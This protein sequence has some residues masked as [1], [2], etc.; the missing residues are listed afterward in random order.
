MKLSEKR[1]DVWVWFVATYFEVYLYRHECATQL[2]Y[3]H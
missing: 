3:F 2:S 1:D